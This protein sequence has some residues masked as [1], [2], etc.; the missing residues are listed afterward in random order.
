MSTL[1]FL[2]TQKSKNALQKIAK[3]SLFIKKFD[4]FCIKKKKNTTHNRKCQILFFSFFFKSCKIKQN[5]K[6]V[7]C[8]D[9]LKTLTT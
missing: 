1:S 5:I 7:K 9:I 2:K 3:N 4:C 6:C 8:G